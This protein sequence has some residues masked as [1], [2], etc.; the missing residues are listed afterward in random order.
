MFRSLTKCK[1]VLKYS[2]Y[3]IHRYNLLMIYCPKYGYK[4]SCAKSQKS[5]EQFG[6]N[7]WKSVILS[8]LLQILACLGYLRSNKF[9]FQA[10]VSVVMSFCKWLPSLIRKIRKIVRAVWLQYLITC[11]FKFVLRQCLACFGHLQSNKKKF[12]S[13]GQ[14]NLSLWAFF[15]H[16]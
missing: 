1:D 16:F 4:N 3:K 15:D 9:F 5:L 11:H 7:T 6:Q 8:I 2:V 14:K 10:A 13:S 12:S